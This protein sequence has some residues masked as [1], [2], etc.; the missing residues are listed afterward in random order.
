MNANTP[1]NDGELRSLFVALVFMA[2]SVTV[3]LFHGLQG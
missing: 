2:A 1:A 3:T